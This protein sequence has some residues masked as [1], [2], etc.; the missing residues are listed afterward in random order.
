MKVLA[1]VGLIAL[2]AFSMGT[3]AV[4]CAL[5]SKT[6]LSNIVH[7]LRGLV[8]PRCGYLMFEGA[9]RCPECG[10]AWFGPSKEWREETLVA[11]PDPSSGS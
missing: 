1:A 9:E 3:I 6:R 4:I 8:C 11:L 10:R 7:A 5:L 2:G